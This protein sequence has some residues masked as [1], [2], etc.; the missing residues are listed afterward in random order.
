MGMFGW[1][2]LLELDDTFLRSFFLTEGSDDV[3]GAIGGILRLRG[4]NKHTS[5]RK[6]LSKTCY[7]AS[8]KV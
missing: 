8:G 4:F 7:S 3:E 2:C 1:V 5:A 6:K